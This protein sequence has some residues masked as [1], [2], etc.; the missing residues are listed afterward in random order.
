MVVVNKKTGA[1]K[2][3][4]EY[5]T[6]ILIIGILLCLVLVNTLKRGDFSGNINS[7]V[8]AAAK[9]ANRIDPHTLKGK[10][11]TVITLDEGNHSFD[12]QPIAV[13]D[14]PF[15][16]LTENENLEKIRNA[17][18]SLAIYSNSPEISSKAWVILNQMGISNLYILD[19]TEDEVLKYKFLPDTVK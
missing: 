8:E 19:M 11:W 7:A 5:K 1:M 17:G 13:I 10:N 2:F 12:F 9:G 15:R 3:F 4:K 6:V 18:S 16:K 14:I